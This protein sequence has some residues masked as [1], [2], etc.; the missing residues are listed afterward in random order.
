[1]ELEAL[2]KSQGITNTT[3]K[4]KGTRK[5]LSG[6]LTLCVI[7]PEPVSCLFYRCQDICPVNRKE[8]EKSSDE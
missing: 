6:N 7:E 8:R 2:M 5:T 3:G 4:Q 1:M